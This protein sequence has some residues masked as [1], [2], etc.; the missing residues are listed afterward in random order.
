MATLSIT[1]SDL[2]STRWQDGVRGAR[3][4]N[5]S[6]GR[7]V[8]SRARR[9]VIHGF[10]GS[11]VR[12]A[13]LV[14]GLDAQKSYMDRGESALPVSALKDGRQ[15]REESSAKPPVRFLL[16]PST[17]SLVGEPRASRGA[18]R[19]RAKAW[20]GS[21]SASQ[22]ARL[23]RKIDNMYR[24]FA[25]VSVSALLTAGCAGS[26][27]LANGPTLGG[28]QIASRRPPD[29]LSNGPESCE[30]NPRAN[31]RRPPQCSQEGP[32]LFASPAIAEA[33]PLA[34]MAALPLAPVRRQQEL[35][36]LRQ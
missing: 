4:S 3:P 1:S 34:E 15:I 22:T 8:T 21:S 20:R 35:T 12:L 19:R 33:T 36:R 23:R 27:G 32:S 28:S 16:I 5:G 10:D 30:R 31:G 24:I 18:R 14:G 11:G 17:G 29:A 25:F 6:I 7:K 26:V 2:G 9:N 13:G